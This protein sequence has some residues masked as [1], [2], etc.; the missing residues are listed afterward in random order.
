MCSRR[1]LDS[2]DPDR[3]PE[4][5]R[6]ARREA[7]ELLGLDLRRLLSL[8]SAAPRA[9]QLTARSR[10]QAAERR[11]AATPGHSLSVL[12]RWVAEKLFTQGSLV[13]RRR[14]LRRPP[15]SCCLRHIYVHLLYVHLPYGG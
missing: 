9:R 7:S 15:C 11:S 3:V 12:A 6:G 4:P 10:P 2:V 5:F 13:H 8:P 14:R 1:A